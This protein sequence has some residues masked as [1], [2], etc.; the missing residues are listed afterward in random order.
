MYLPDRNNNPAQEINCSNGNTNCLNNNG[1]P[2]LDKYFY[3]SNSGWLFFYVAQTGLMPVPRRVEQLRWVR[4]PARREPIPSSVPR[5][6]GVLRTPEVITTMS[7]PQKAA[8]AI[9]PR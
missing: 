9:Q 2:Q 8:G 7:A 3:D 5:R 1:T 6:S 4:V